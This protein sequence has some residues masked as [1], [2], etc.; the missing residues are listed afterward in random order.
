M[1]STTVRVNRETH[2]LLQ[3]LAAQEHEPASRIIQKALVDYRRR[4]FLLKLGEAYGALRSDAAAW[5]KETSERE[6]WDATI[7]DGIDKDE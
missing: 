3:E 1:Q 6:T 2:V 4:L 5:K 7:D